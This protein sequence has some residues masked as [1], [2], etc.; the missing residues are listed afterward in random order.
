MTIL[1][2]VLSGITSAVMSV[3]SLTLIILIL[4]DVW[5]RQGNPVDAMGYHSVDTW[6]LPP[7]FAICRKCSPD[8]AL[9]GSSLL[10]VLNERENDA[11]LSTRVHPVHFQ[12]QL[13][14]ATGQDITC[15]NMCTGMQMVSESYLIV[16]ALAN[17]PSY[18]PVIIYGTALRDFMYDPMRY[19]WTTGCFRSAAPYAPV[20][21][22]IMSAMSSPIACQDFVLSHFW[23]LYRNRTDFN[24][25][26][27]AWCKNLL[28]Y[29]PLDQSFQRINFDH[30][31]MPARTGFLWEEWVARKHLEPQWKR[32]PQLLKALV[33]TE[34]QMAFGRGSEL[35]RAVE[36][37]YFEAMG[38]FC[39]RKG[40]KLVVINMP[41]APETTKLAPPGLNDAFRDYLKMVA[42]KYDIK[43]ID[44]SGSTEYP[45]SAFID[46]AHL[47]YLYAV[48]FSDQIVENLSKNFPDVLQAMGAHA[49][50]RSQ[51][52][53]SK[54]VQE[55]PFAD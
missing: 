8:V 44:L 23:Y 4:L 52:P 21:T 31:Y 36:A 50:I 42:N 29:L 32:N 41:L 34:H 25:V 38:D 43:L 24:D 5:L 9:I 14:Q 20:E 55:A 40:I 48:K 26:S 30:D 6:N 17:Q 53:A 13:R 12:S 37:R 45:S 15:L 28:E 35:T 10:L 22:D 47:K 18:P 39:R 49:A 51:H 1:K 16:R 3:P 7:N 33:R 46:G 2:R 54:S 27:S 11:F 19:E